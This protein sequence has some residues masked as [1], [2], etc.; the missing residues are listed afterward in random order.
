MI[1][2]DVREERNIFAT[3]GTLNYHRTSKQ[4]VRWKII[5]MYSG[6][7]PSKKKYW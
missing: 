2:T 1:T 7:P 4:K 5:K 6:L 3:K